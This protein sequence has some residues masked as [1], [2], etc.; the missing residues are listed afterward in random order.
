MIIKFSA[1]LKK[2]VQPHIVCVLTLFVLMLLWL[3]IFPHGLADNGDFFRIIHNLGLSHLGGTDSDSYFNYFTDKYWLTSYFID[4]KV[5]FLS[6]Q[7]IVIMISIGLSH[8]FNNG[9]IY[10]IRF[11]A[12]VYGVIYLIACYIIL[13]FIVFFVKTVFKNESA[14]FIKIVSW[15]CPLLFVFVFGDFS[16]LLYFNSFFGEPL[17]FTMLLMIVALTLKILTSKK[18]NILLLILYFLSIVMFI[19]AKQQNAPLGLLFF[20]FALSLTTLY[21]NK[22]WRI[23]VIVGCVVITVSS[24]VTYVAISGDIRYINQYDALTTG[25]MRYSQ[26]ANDLKAIGLDPQLEILKNSTV[27][28][29]YP[30][31]LPD[32]PIMYKKLYNQ[33]SVFKIS[34]YYV[35]NPDLL[36]RQLKSAIS[37]SFVIKAGMVGNY[38]KSSHK[39]PLAKSY[40]FSLYS[41][42]KEFLMSYSSGVVIFIFFIFY[43]ALGYI[44]SQFFKTRYK[45]GLLAIEFIL[46]IGLMAIMQ[47]LI[48]IIGSGDADL[49]KHFFLFNVDFDL[50]FL[51]SVYC[52]IYLCRLIF[53]KF[54]S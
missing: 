35:K 48:T 1:A 42:I 21:K 28:E 20:L 22:N 19:G 6:T 15:I 46:L 38:L 18:S 9:N 54:T 10:D 49:A 29:R 23:S 52:L 53:D 16:Y 50:L 33:V 39:P 25:F 36:L 32:S 3:F 2:F 27:Y 44:Y 14:V 7:T 17:S 31:I 30:V 13:K 40:F 8:I 5:S 51:F 4:N 41:T 43:S 11:L 37:N 45:R 12:L 26:S 47:L 34:L 24:V